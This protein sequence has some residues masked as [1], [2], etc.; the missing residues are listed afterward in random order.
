MPEKKQQ[1]VSDHLITRRGMIKLAAGAA[2]TG[3]VGSSLTRLARAA[4]RDDRPNII[5]ILAD[6]M[7]WD[8]AGFKGHPFINTPGIDRLAAEGVVFDN[9]FNTTALCSPSRA[10]I[11]TGTYAH[12]H[13]VLNNHTP[14]TG[15]H[16]IF[17]DYLKK[18]GYDNAFVGKWH[19]PGRGLPNIPSLDLFASYTYREGQGSY[20]ICPFIVTESRSR[21]QENIS[22]MKRPTVPS[23]SWNGGDPC[24]AARAGPSVSTFRTGRHTLP[25]GLPAISRECMTGRRLRCRMWWTHG[26]P[27]QTATCSRAS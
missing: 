25:T 17:F 1:D 20:F 5:F 10:S 12:T 24:P 23:P 9:A 21:L 6:N 22:L 15:R 7:R 27:V 26:S 4:A 2:A 3:V 8:C 13:G 16:P 19:M 14:W 11:L 18:A